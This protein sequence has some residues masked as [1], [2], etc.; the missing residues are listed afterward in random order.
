[1]TPLRRLN[2]PL[3][4]YLAFV[5]GLWALTVAQLGIALERVPLSAT[6]L[7]L[8]IAGRPPTESRP[9][10]PDLARAARVAARLAPTLGA[11]NYCVRHS[12]I[13]GHLLRA[14]GPAL[15]IG[16]RR[17]AGSIDAHAWIEI[18]GAAI[19]R[20]TTTAAPDFVTLRRA[21]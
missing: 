5:R 14:H 8:S 15:R 7:G 1:M 21:P 18:G 4:D 12:L 9:S 2:R 11:R 20:R 13:L 16:V 6:L 19:E 17:A 3:A 10:D